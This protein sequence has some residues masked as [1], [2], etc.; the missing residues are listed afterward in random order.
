MQGVMCSRNFNSGTLDFSVEIYRSAYF[1][2][3]LFFWTCYIAVLLDLYSAKSYWLHK[4][5]ISSYFD[6]ACSVHGKS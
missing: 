4:S 2:T 3:C 1:E 6:T 5:T